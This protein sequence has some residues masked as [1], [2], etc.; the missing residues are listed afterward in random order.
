M[1]VCKKFKLLCVVVTIVIVILSS[2]ACSSVTEQQATR[3]K[4]DKVSDQEKQRM[5]DLYFAM[6]S[7]CR[8]LSELDYQQFPSD[9]N[10]WNFDINQSSIAFEFDTGISPIMAYLLPETTI[11]YK[12]SL[13][14]Y[15][16]CD[17]TINCEPNSTYMF[18]P[19]VSLLDSNFSPIYSLLPGDLSLINPDQIQQ[20][21]QGYKFTLDIEAH[22]KAK[23]I[24]IFTTRSL[25]KRG[26]EYSYKRAAAVYSSNGHPITA[27]PF[28]KFKISIEER[29]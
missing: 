25:I 21:Q 7:C 13:Q 11:P 19:V 4:A 14:S 28:G 27:L 20:K 26:V 18:I 3:A 2:S 5:L 15:S 16:L 22:N 23:Y 12:F 24:I 8:K 10:E 6:K 1:K 9:K 17:K 29:P